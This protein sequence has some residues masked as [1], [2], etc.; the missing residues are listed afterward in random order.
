MTVLTKIGFGK[1]VTGE[2]VLLGKGD[3]LAGKIVL[4]LSPVGRE[5]LEKAG[6]VGVAGVIVPSMPY[7]DYRYFENLNEFPLLVLLKFG[8]LELEESLLEKMQKLAGKKA[9][10]DGHSHELKTD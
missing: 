2:I 10:L 4:C 3:D 8:K 5:F 9:T 1:K 6:L 7:R